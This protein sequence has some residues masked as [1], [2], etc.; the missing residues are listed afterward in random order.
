MD[1]ILQDRPKNL[2]SI[3][4]L[5]KICILYHFWR[6]TTR[7]SVKIVVSDRHS[8]TGFIVVVSKNEWENSVKV[9]LR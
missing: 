1:M 8:L 6:L 7:Y 5:R 2:K 9:A 4:N 3:G